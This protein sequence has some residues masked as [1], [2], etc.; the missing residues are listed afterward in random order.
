MIAN[1]NVLRLD[2]VRLAKMIARTALAAGEIV[3]GVWLLTGRAEK[4]AA[5][6]SVALLAFVGTACALL[7]PSLLHQ[8]FG[9]ISKNLGL[10]ACA[11]VVWLLSEPSRSASPRKKSHVP[12]QST[13]LFAT[14]KEEGA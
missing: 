11:L 1:V 14:T 3:G 12:E 10:V 4:T 13:A 8:P 6:I 2:R 5:A 7:D 9:A